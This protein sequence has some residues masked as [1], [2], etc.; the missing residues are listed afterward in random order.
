MLGY[1][2]LLV[3]VLGFGITK[4]FEDYP[5]SFRIA[6]PVGLAFFLFSDWLIG[7]REMTIPGFLPG[8]WVGITYIIGQ[9]LIHLTPFF[10]FRTS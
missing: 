10:G 9:L 3:T 2:V 1:G 5:L 8:P 6:L 4:W 7:V